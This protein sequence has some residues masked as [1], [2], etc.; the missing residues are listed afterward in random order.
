MLTTR[1]CPGLRNLI[2][3]IVVK[4]V[5]NRRKLVGITSSVP[6]PDIYSDTFVQDGVLL[7]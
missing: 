5:S 4:T 2:G 6:Y 1:V 3:A 7:W